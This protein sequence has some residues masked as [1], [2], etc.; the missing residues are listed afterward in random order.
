M[1]AVSY[2]WYPIIG[3]L[4]VMIVGIV[5]SFIPGLRMPSKV[6]RKHLFPCVRKCGGCCRIQ[7]DEEYEEYGQKNGFDP[8]T[9]ENL[10]RY[11]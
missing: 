10:V 2:L 9:K 6:Q 11:K 1:Y 4:V 7:D 8:H 3:I 5:T